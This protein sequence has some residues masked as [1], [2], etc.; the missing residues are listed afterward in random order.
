MKSI[1]REQRTWE[2]WSAEIGYN[3]TGWRSF[4]QALRQHYQAD[5]LLPS[6][7]NDP[8][9][10][11]T[12]LENCFVNLALIEQV[13][14]ERHERT[15]V[16]GSPEAEAALERGE[17]YQTLLQM[18]QTCGVDSLLGISEDR[19][20]LLD[21]LCIT[22]RAGTGKT[23]L[24]QYIAYRWAMRNC[25]WFNRFDFVFR[26]KLNLVGQNDF[27]LGL[28]EKN[29]TGLGYLAWLIHKSLAGFSEVASLKNIRECL[30]KFP[31]KALLLLD[32]FDE[33]QA[34]YGE[35]RDSKVTT[36][37]DYAMTFPNGIV[38]SR[39]NA[40]PTPWSRQKALGGRFIQ[41]FE[42]LGLT[43]DNVRQYI[44]QYFIAQPNIASHL[45][46]ELSTNSQMMGLAQIPVNITAL[47]LTYNRETV[48]NPLNSDNPSSKIFTMTMLYHRVVAWLARRYY[49]QFK[50]TPEEMTQ[51][52]NPTTVKASIIFERCHIELQALAHLAYDAFIHGEVQSLSPGLLDRHFPEPTLL[53]TLSSQLGVLRAFSLSTE[54]DQY[55]PHYFVHL[56]YQEYFTALYMAQRLAI[57]ENLTREKEIQRRQTIQIIARLI[58]TERNNP[59]YA[60]VFVFLSGLVS[61]PEYAAGADY[62]W[63]AIIPEFTGAE[64]NTS[65]Y[66]LPFTFS[67]LTY[68][69]HGYSMLT[70]LE[71][72][73]GSDYFWGA[74]TRPFDQ[75]NVFALPTI[76]LH[77]QVRVLK[78]YQKTIQEALLMHKAFHSFSQPPQRLQILQTCRHDLFQWN[79]ACQTKLLM[80]LWDDE[81]YID[82]ATQQQRKKYQYFQQQYQHDAYLLEFSILPALSISSILMNTSLWD[83]AVEATRKACFPNHYSSSEWDIEN[84]IRE[85]KTYSI[86]DKVTQ[87]MLQ[88]ILTDP[89][90]D[91]FYEFE[92]QLNPCRYD[93][94]EKLKLN[95]AEAL[96]QIDPS[97]EKALQIL[98]KN[99]VSL[100]NNFYH[101]VKIL[102]KITVL[103]EITLQAIRDLLQSH[104]SSYRSYHL[105]TINILRKQKSLDEVSLAAL[106]ILLMDEYEGVRLNAAYALIQVNPTDVQAIQILRDS[107]KNGSGYVWSSVYSDLPNLAKILL[108]IYPEDRQVIQ[109]L[110]DQLKSSYRVL[111]REAAEILLHIEA[112]HK[113][114]LTFLLHY[115]MK[116]KNARER[117]HIADF[118]GNSG[119]QD[120]AILAGLC[121]A[122]QDD[123][124]EVRHSAALALGQLGV[125]NEAILEGLR[126]SLI[127]PG[128]DPMSLVSWSAMRSLKQLRVSD[129]TTLKIIKY[130]IYNIRYDASTLSEAVQ[131]LYRIQPMDEEVLNLLKH[132]LEQNNF[133][134]FKSIAETLYDR[135]M[136]LA[137]LEK[138]NDINETKLSVAHDVGVTLLRILPIA[139]A[140]LPE[141]VTSSLAQ[142]F[143]VSSAWLHGSTV[144][145]KNYQL[146]VDEQIFPL[147]I[148]SWDEQ[149]KFRAQLTMHQQQFIL[150]V[151]QSSPAFS[152]I[153]NRLTKPIE[154]PYVTSVLEERFL[155]EHLPAIVEDPA[156]VAISALLERL[157]QMQ[158]DIHQRLA[159]IDAL[160]Q[161]QEGDL[162][163]L[164]EDLS[165]AL[166]Q[167]VRLHQKVSAAVS[168][169]DFEPIAENVDTLQEQVSQLMQSQL[170]QPKSAP[171]VAYT[172]GRDLWQKPAVMDNQATERDVNIKT[173]FSDS[174][175]NTGAL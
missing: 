66:A 138:M 104:D 55:P 121:H 140:A 114:A 12:S 18:N 60:I 111:R 89:A 28:S 33:I 59:R 6:L 143:F 24:L 21:W 87:N 134:F 13:E 110:R 76:G 32:G 175:N 40:I 46:T 56:T 161:K 125:V 124:L 9:L 57:P 139:Y 39:P 86:V 62:F 42:N 129:E 80:S 112:T 69:P 14:H 1:Q 116:G 85:L 131:V 27:W 90:D 155:T 115:L 105:Y 153:L 29:H 78:I 162:T 20:K 63:D 126:Y 106:R 167:V 79:N 98:R 128:I 154:L 163:Q 102:E 38:T 165:G 147:P 64:I 8:T 142:R 88:R 166:S 164:G 174:S 53:Y 97:N 17:L 4:I 94:S 15:L 2:K 83:T 65:G 74:E 71:Y 144:C 31:E 48:A 47:C 23:T 5:N 7:V 100:G 35:G 11:R 122:L 119:I 81:S 132:M 95:A 10:P 51:G 169:A 99:L 54:E 73:G 61:M 107:L 137:L 159:S 168:A 108:G 158:L 172:M 70:S 77:P 152:E 171:C 58:Q 117:Y 91:E 157:D 150:A 173:V 120:E 113:E 141:L 43:E 148:S 37:V 84:A 34:L 96:I 44:R 67:N 82:K 146:I 123:S 92:I 41:Q 49:T 22:G 101:S 170:S 45:I 135:T 26:V 50:L 16:N 160:N 151:A 136:I 156:Q 149:Q 93:F 103:D 133:S 109:S 118:F 127:D 145:I 36:L 25:S 3:V 30:T 52:L 68:A 19:T 72:A 130:N 75:K